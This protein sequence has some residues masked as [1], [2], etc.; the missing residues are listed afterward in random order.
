LRRRGPGDRGR[1]LARPGRTTMQ[2]LIMP[3]QNRLTV[4]SLK[5]GSKNSHPT[6]LCR[7][8]CGNLRTVRQTKLRNGLVVECAKCA[9]AKGAIE[10]GKK[11][12]KHSPSENACLRVFT[13]YKQNARK[14]GLKFALRPDEVRSLLVGNC[15]YCG[16]KPSTKARSNDGGL[17]V[18]NGIDRIDSSLG[19]ERGNVV[20]CCQLCNY[21]KRSLT[22]A[23]FI[24]LAR[25]ITTHQDSK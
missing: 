17:F 11:M 5:R 22:V 18:Y 13:S 10:A 14:K 23:E 7:C 6:A 15:V 24:D 4:L 1:V 3:K 19:Y 16:A 9:H 20:S 2:P 25:Q 21:A 12:R 8:E